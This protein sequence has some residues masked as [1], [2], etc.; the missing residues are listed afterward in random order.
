[1][2]GESLAR[3]HALCKTAGGEG[4]VS[5]ETYEAIEHYT[6]L[7]LKWNQAINL[8]SKATEGDVW[9]RHILDSAQLFPLILSYHNT[10]NYPVILTDFGSGGG[11]PALVIAALLEGKNVP[12]HLHAIESDKRKAI[13]LTQAAHAIG[14]AS[15]HLTIHNG[16]AEK[17]TPWE[18]NII[19]ARGFAPLSE[20]F[21]YIVPFT[22]KK[23]LSLLQKG[24]RVEQELEVASKRWVYD[25]NRIAS[26]TE[27]DAVIL[28]IQN[29]VPR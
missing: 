13:F 26:L 27:H 24:S 6:A 28:S 16:R 12:Y 29:I 11:L 14:I 17:M 9:Y 21:S 5:R 22:Q 23:C 2:I 20:L 4:N 19:L 15:A 18:S 8:I 10:D 3:Y 25:V 7:L 1:M